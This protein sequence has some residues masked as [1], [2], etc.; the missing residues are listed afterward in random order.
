M[1]SYHIIAFGCQMNEHDA[2]VMAGSLEQ[3]GYEYTDNRDEADIIMINTCCVRETAEN[4]VYGLLGR[5]RKL[6]QNKPGLIIGI[7]GCMT[8]QE[9]TAS[10]IKRRFSHVDLIFGTHSLH[11]LPDLISEIE[12]KR[13]SL[14]IH[15]PEHM[16]IHENLPIK[17]SP[18]VKSWVP[19]TYGCNNYCTYCIVPYV[20]G[21]ERSR[22]PGDIIADITGLAGA[23]YKEVTLLGQ[24]VNSYGKDL[25]NTSFADL[26]EHVN[27]IDGIERIR[28]MTSHPRDFS[29]ELINTAAGLEKVCEHI[30]LP[31]QAGSN[32]ILRAM[33][34]GYTREYYIDLVERIRERIPGV[35]L[36]T[37]IMVGFPGET[38]EDFLYTVDIV[39][40]LRFEGAFTFI[41]NIRQ[42]TPAAKMPGQISEEEKSLR[43]QKL[44]AVQN[45][46]SLQLNG[47]EAGRIHQVLVEGAS[48]T[49]ENMLTGRTR[50]NKLVV[51]P[52]RSCNP[53]DTVQVRIN[54]GTLTYL[55]GEIIG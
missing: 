37:D 21:R 52:D 46:I 3:L 4:K 27:S 55:E 7:G 29:E 47:E 35:A 41:Y 6:K 19:V 12:E 18:G 51:F 42:G 20:R 34:R 33:N 39:E 43:I 32:S 22:K 38:E 11:E 16:G 36:T 30:H 13:K 1:K 25:G 26:L 15:R 53:G 44:V 28:F 31:V 40:K 49:N 48:K 54:G 9:E 50:T 23:G 14:L 8:Q 24:N 10:K 2:E 45:A 17:R 5:L